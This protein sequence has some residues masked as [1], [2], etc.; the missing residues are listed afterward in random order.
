MNILLLNILGATFLGSF[1][2]LLGGIILLAVRGRTTLRLTHFFSAF[3]AGA[4]LATAFLDLL[5]E[6][7]AVGTEI[8]VFRWT[9]FG[10]FGFY[11]LE[12]GVHWF[13]HH[14]QH[15]GEAHGAEHG[16]AHHAATPTLIL[17]GGALH[18]FID[19][20]AIAASFIASPALGLLTALAV[21]AHEIPKELGDFAVLLDRGMRRGRV[22]LLNMLSACAAFVG[23]IATWLLTEHVTGLLPI[24]FSLTAGLFAYIALS[25]LIPEIHQRHPRGL[26]VVE[27]VFLVSG[28]VLVGAAVT[29]LEQ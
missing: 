8:N 20:A 12:R 4:L 14:T 5:P 16:H 6:A 22:L 24:L 23:A 19:G 17:I 3:A 28:A 13:H 27:T 26:A 1:V 9:L 11:L 10:I 29:V 15:E 7:Q 21:G 18:N 2:S 25:D